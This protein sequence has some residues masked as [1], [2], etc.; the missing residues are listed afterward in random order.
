MKSSHE[1]RHRMTEKHKIWRGLAIYRVAASPYWRA[2]YYDRTA[3]RYVVASTKETL[4]RNA[5]LA[6]EQMVRSGTLNA[7]IVEISKELPFEKTFEYFARQSIL[8]A[9]VKGKPTALRDHSKLLEKANDGLLD[10]FG[11][12]NISEITA[13]DITEYFSTIDEARD[14]PLSQSTK[15]H[16]RIA[17]GKVF[18]EA[19]ATGALT[20]LPAIPVFTPDDNPTPS[21]TMSEYQHLLTV[22]H[23]ERPS[24]IPLITFMVSTY[25]RPMTSELMAI[26]W[27][28][29]SPRGKD[30]TLQIKI[31]RGKT[32]KGRTVI[33]QTDGVGI[34][35]SLIA[36]E[37]AQYLFFPE[38]SDRGKA[39]TDARRQFN[40]VL[41][42]AKL[43]ID[44][45][46]SQRILYSL[47]HFGIQQRLQATGG[48][49]NLDTLARNAGTS[50]EMLQRFY[51]ARMSVNDEMVRNLQGTQLIEREKMLRDVANAT[52]TASRKAEQA[53][54]IKRAIEN[55]KIVLKVG[56]TGVLEIKGL[57]KE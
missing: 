36:G 14:E 4:K 51:L 47:R 19:I 29:I 40:Q 39:M 13:A 16:Y 35:K 8:T 49:V 27:G 56:E 3:K 28:D 44:L 34:L 32:G 15:N 20:R 5:I 12:R 52:V 25:V 50:V 6:A 26:R 45:D 1:S 43:K 7:P 41:E 23:R 17:L 18:K 46:G 10:Y 42:E 57:A 54:R 37:P 2:R 30:G 24:L 48:N 31:L 9:K 33:S 21:F 55:G 53:G 11:K 38:H 22:A